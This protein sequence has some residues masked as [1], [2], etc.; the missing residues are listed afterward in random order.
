MITDTLP[1]TLDPSTFELGVRS[2]ACIPQLTG[3]GVLRFIFPNIQLPDSNTNEP[4]SHGLVQFRIKP[5]LPLVPGT[6]IENIANIYFDFNPPIITEPSVLVAEFSTGVSEHS[7][8]EMLIYPNPASDGFHVAL[9][10]KRTAQLSLRDLH[11][12]VVRVVSVPND[13]IWM[14]T[15]G[16]ADGSY[17]MEAISTSGTRYRSMV[18]IIKY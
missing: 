14:D 6:S 8:G 2:N 13:R 10:G 16:L 11:G 17:L 4:R 5:K 12:R 7:S 15:S 18:Q 3:Q 9:S 1:S